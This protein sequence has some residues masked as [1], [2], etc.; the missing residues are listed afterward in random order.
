[1][2]GGIHYAFLF[3]PQRL[4][5]Q[6]KPVVTDIDAESKASG[7]SLGASGV[8]D[9]LAVLDTGSDFTWLPHS[10][11]QALDIYGRPEDTV[12]DPTETIAGIVQETIGI[13]SLR[14]RLNG[15]C[16]PG[17]LRVRCP[18]SL[19]DRGLT[20]AVIGQDVLGKFA[21]YH[22]QGRCKGWLKQVPSGRFAGFLWR[23]CD[24]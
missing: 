11:L 20:Y 12:D 19:E 21:M 16:V 13:W 3:N 1:M 5:G 4:G 9:T 14:L 17:W 15:C 8:E 7:R 18:L 24:L 10:W 22:N 23:L 2:G 6:P